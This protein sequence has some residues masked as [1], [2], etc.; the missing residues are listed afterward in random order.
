MKSTGE[1]ISIAKTIE[2]AAYKAFY[3]YLVKK[4]EAHEIY[5][6]APADAKSFIEQAQQQGVTIVT[7]EPFEQ[8]V[9][10]K[11]RLRL[12]ALC[13]MNKVRGEENKRSLAMCSC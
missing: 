9:A 3:P 12:L 2:E 11:R 7:D 10:K 6:D 5:V 8:W 13:V 1:G 4:K